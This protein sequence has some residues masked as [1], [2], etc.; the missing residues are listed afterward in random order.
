MA[1]E[2]DPYL[3]EKFLRNECSP[4]EVEVV[5]SFF[6]E[7][8]A[9]MDTYF[10]IN[11]WNEVVSTDLLTDDRK[12]VLKARI[13]KGICR[14]GK[15]RRMVFLKY[16]AA[17]VLAGIVALLIR[18]DY[19][20]SQKREVGSMVSQTRHVL[21]NRAD[22]AKD[23]TLPDGSLVVLAPGARLSYGED[24]MEKRVVAVEAGA[25]RFEEKKIKGKPFSILSQSVETVPIGTRFWVRSDIL[26]KEVEIVLEQGKL[27]INSVDRS[28]VMQEVVL[29]EGQKALVNT[30]TMAVAISDIRPKKMIVGKKADSLVVGGKN[31]AD[32]VWTNN[33]I[34]FNQ[35]A[36]SIVLDKIADRYNKHIMYDKPLV[37]KYTFT[38]EIY[39]TD[40]IEILLRNICDV[41]GLEYESKGDTILIQKIKN[42]VSQ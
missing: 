35:A 29:N 33:M 37:A 16:M 8:P 30:E 18:L 6:K 32:V 19:S 27:K 39:Y 38:G 34:Q 20:N 4:D 7:H 12:E 40:D 41:N 31:I 5:A 10:D 24:Y 11:E 3:I 13:D 26:R 15:V 25:A 23:T 28:R 14:E 17:A 9:A 36:L 42:H 21:F 2:V 22:M 1:Q